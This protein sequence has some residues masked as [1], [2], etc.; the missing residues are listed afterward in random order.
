MIYESVFALMI[1]LRPTS[2]PIM[3]NIGEYHS[4]KECDTIKKG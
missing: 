4:Y 2:M 3:Q 1:I